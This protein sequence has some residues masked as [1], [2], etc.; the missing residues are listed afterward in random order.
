MHPMDWSATAAW[1][2]L[3]I[4]I[5]GTIVGPIVTTILTN[6]HQLKL[7][8]LDIYEEQYKDFICH[9]RNAIVNFISYTGQYIAS[10]HTTD[11][12]NCSNHFFPVYAYA[13]KSIWSN[14]DDLYV[15]IVQGNDSDAQKQ[16]I[17]INRVLSAILK[18]APPTKP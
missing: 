17:E 13:P 9:R 4:S 10:S 1:I 16:F 6:R 7:R 14:L 12:K 2:A 8:K 15:H 5:T 18:E 11:L 3:A